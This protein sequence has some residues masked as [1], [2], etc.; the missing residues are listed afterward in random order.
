MLEV[1]PQKMPLFWRTRTAGADTP[2]DNGNEFYSAQI[3]G[4]KQ[5]SS[6]SVLEVKKKEHTF[7]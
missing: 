6:A 1:K 4:Q 3:L 2:G 7:V 5:P